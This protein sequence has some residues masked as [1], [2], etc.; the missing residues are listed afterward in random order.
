[1]K[2]DESVLKKLIKEDNMWFLSIIG[3]VLHNIG[4]I[5]VAMLVLKSTAVL[6]YFPFLLISGCIA[7]TF[8]GICAQ[9]VSSRMKKADK[10]HL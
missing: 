6:G 9:L 7:G 4:Q 5:S 10:A 1:M 3:A 8:T 2:I